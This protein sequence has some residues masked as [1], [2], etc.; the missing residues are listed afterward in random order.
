MTEERRLMT[1]GVPLDD[2]ISICHALRRERDEL[3][4]LI[5]QK[6]AE[7]RRIWE[8]ENEWLLTV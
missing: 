7:R 6:E 5:H 4:E 2:A 3:P 1:V 8:E